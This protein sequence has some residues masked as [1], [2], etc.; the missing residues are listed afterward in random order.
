MPKNVPITR[1]T[2]K[3]PHA[4]A[5]TAR[6]VTTTVVVID[7]KLSTCTGSP[8][9]DGALTTLSLV[10]GPVL[11]VVDRV[12]LGDVL[13]MVV[14]AALPFGR[15]VVGCTPGTRERCLPPCRDPFILTILTT[16]SWLVGLAHADTVLCR[17]PLQG[18]G[19]QNQPPCLLAC[20]G[21]ASCCRRTRESRTSC[22][23]GQP[24]RHGS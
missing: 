11:V 7:R 16:L 23:T 6:P 8:L 15:P 17:P 24:V 3:A 13:L 10:D 14:V 12:R 19:Y 18:S 21:P 22:R 1:P 20:P 9:A 2:K 4:L 5:T